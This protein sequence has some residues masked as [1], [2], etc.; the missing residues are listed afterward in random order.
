MSKGEISIIKLFSNKKKFTN[1]IFLDS[2]QIPNTWLYFVL[3]YIN[4]IEKIIDYLKE[5]Q[6]DDLLVKINALEDKKVKFY[7]I[8]GFELTGNNK[9]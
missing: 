6:A 5:N 4:R 1:E 8:I 7:E 3:L 9:D 2:K